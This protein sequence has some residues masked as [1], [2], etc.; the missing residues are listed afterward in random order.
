MT[1]DITDRDYDAEMLRRIV[2][3]LDDVLDEARSYHEEHRNEPYSFCSEFV[4]VGPDEWLLVYVHSDRCQ[5]EMV[6]RDG[7]VVGTQRLSQEQLEAWRTTVVTEVMLKCSEHLCEVVR[8]ATGREL[9]EGYAAAVL[10]AAMTYASAV[11][12]SAG[13]ASGRV[14]RRRPLLFEVRELLKSLGANKDGL[15]RATK[16]YSTS[17]EIAQELAERTI[18]GCER[19]EWGP[20]FLDA[21]I[22]ALLDLEQIDTPRNTEAARQSLHASGWRSHEY[23]GYAERSDGPPVVVW[24]QPD[25]PNSPPVHS[26]IDAAGILAADLAGNM[27]QASSAW[28]DVPKLPKVP[29]PQEDQAHKEQY[30]TRKAAYLEAHEQWLHLAYHR[31]DPG[32]LVMADA[33]GVS[34]TLAADAL[35]RWARGSERVAAV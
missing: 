19:G 1:T 29:T 3:A 5:L 6:S 26:D 30:S 24:H 22:E 28:R 12:N 2:P 13:L 9:D 34:E 31:G 10:R 35:A 18:N 21:T 16:L 8:A 27:A 17:E 7:D 33:W 15:I 25:L 23:I 4:R 11:F 14:S 20:W 32:P